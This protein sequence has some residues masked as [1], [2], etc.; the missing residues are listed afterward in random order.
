MRAL[1]SFLALTL[2]AAAAASAGSMPERETRDW[3]ELAGRAASRHVPVLVVVDSP[4]CGYCARLREEV[5]AP[6]DRRGELAGRAVVG[7]MALRAGGKV[8]DFDGEKVR[9]QVFLRRY[10]VFATPTLLFLDPAGHPLHDPL[11]GYSGL[12]SYPELLAE[13]L[14][15]SQARLDGD[16]RLAASQGIARA[17][18]PVG[19]R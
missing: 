8:V 7:E 5:L 15:A 13:A 9:S 4:D 10:G 18:A 17:N 3:G 11:V 16:P 14:R 2:V 19:T 1:L 6:M 12:D